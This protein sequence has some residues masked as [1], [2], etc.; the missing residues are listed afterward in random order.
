MSKHRGLSPSDL[1]TF[2]EKDASILQKELKNRSTWFINLR[3]IVPPAIILGM[4]TATVLGFEI[5]AT[6]MLA[7]IA[8]M[9]LGYNVLFWNINRQSLA[10]RESQSTNPLKT[11]TGWQVVLDYCSV[12]LL[13]HFTG[14]IA[15]PLLFLFLF[16]IIF[17]SI[18]LD[19]LI[20]LGF[21]AIVIIGMIALSIS[22]YVG[23]MENYTLVFQGIPITDLASRPSGVF[24][25]LLVFSFTIAVTAISI[26]SILKKIRERIVHLVELST[27]INTLNQRLDVLLAMI[28][29]IG[30]E[31]RLDTV[32]SFVTDELTRVMEVQGVSVKLLSDDRRF[33]RYMASYGLAD[34]IVEKNL[35]EVAK[36]PLNERV[37]N[38]EP[39]VTGDVSQSEQFQFAV[40]LVAW[41]IQSVLLVPLIAGDQVNGILGAYSKQR[42][43][44]SESDIAFFRLAAGLVAVSIDNAV[45][46]E[47]VENVG[48]ERAWFMM[49]VAHNLKAPLSAISSML[50][51]LRG[52]FIGDLNDQQKEYL[53]RVD[54]RA[55]TM[56][57]MIG[58]LLSLA[59][60][61]RERQQLVFKTI[62]FNWLTERL[63][64][65]FMD[66]AARKDMTFEIISQPN[67]PKIQGDP[68][69]IEQMMENLVSNAIR[70]S[71]PGGKVSIELQ[72]N[73]NHSVR[74]LVC[75]QGIGIPKEAL[76]HIFEE[77]YRAE[78]AKVKEE[79]GTGL[80]MSIVKEIVDQHGGTIHIESEEN[81]GTVVAVKLPVRSGALLYGDT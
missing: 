30:A 57:A 65:T 14:G 51:V 4:I 74:I 38:G 9:I 10:K 39:F 59:Q 66:E 61:R 18:L 7:G 49:K 37:I 56:I 19:Q 40:D 13:I 43:H 5:A 71:S 70:Y 15:S 6:T 46:Y 33:L 1:N 22:E 69:M 34:Q 41:D 67:L 63:S 47:K 75:D 42:E 2:L 25:V 36:S 54:R 20:A 8:V 68:E 60:K 50:S 73:K 53:R 16:H 81:A 79:S 58:E 3:W 31:R 80:G 45:A 27:S 23:W 78:N 26:T 77:F 35:I 24:A 48:K 44:F 17:T 76:G 55:Q 64:R 72:T 62:D 28:V 32:L 52:N 21:S 11:F 12:F 29:T